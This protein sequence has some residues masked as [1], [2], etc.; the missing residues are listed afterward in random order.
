MSWNNKDYK[1]I[2]EMNAQNIDI[3]IIYIFLK[4][5]KKKKKEES[6]TKITYSFTGIEKNNRA[7]AGIVILVHQKFENIIGEIE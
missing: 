3:C 5:K 6:D 1:I 2:I 4:M 7:L